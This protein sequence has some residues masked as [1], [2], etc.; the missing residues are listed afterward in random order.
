MRPVVSGAWPLEA[1]LKSR[2]R[3]SQVSMSLRGSH[4][5]GQLLERQKCT[6]DLRLRSI[7]ASRDM[8]NRDK[9]RES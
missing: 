8:W 7:L 9:A 3:P 2:G 4:P 1:S 6:S 5:N